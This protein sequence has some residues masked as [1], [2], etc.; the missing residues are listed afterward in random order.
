MNELK[1]YLPIGT[2]CT[3]SEY[4]KPVMIIGYFSIVYNGN[5]K[6]Y[7]YK[8]CDY[9][10]GMLLDN[11]QIS[12][13]QERIIDV[14]HIGL[15]N[16]QYENFNNNLLKQLENPSEQLETSG[17]FENI[18]FDSH[19]VVIYDNM[20]NSVK[21]KDVVFEEKN[22][23]EISNPFYSAYA[24]KKEEDNKSESW[25]I[26]TDIQFDENGVVISAVENNKG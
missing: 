16:N 15:K 7:D 23:N 10:E 24:E 18:K 9:P 14:L 1:K 17:I 2:V 3:I 26:F 12:F 19:G 5:V 20:V 4:N 22:D 11:K 13:N 8:A 25:P 6:M 21:E